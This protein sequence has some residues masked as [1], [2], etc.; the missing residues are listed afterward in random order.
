MS[1]HTPVDLDEAR[2]ALADNGIDGPDLPYNPRALH[3]M[4][5]ADA[6]LA[7]VATLRAA[8]ASPVAET[9]ARIA[10]AIDAACP[11]EPPYI[12]IGIVP[13]TPEQVDAIA[14]D[15][16]GEPGED[17]RATDRWLHQATGVIRRIV[18]VGVQCRID[19]PAEREMR[20]MREELARL[21]AAVTEARREHG[22]LTGDTDTQGGEPL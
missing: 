15:L 10:T 17:E 8:T 11:G 16:F 14:R 1:N 2:E 20:A 6:L 7:E 18:R 9:L 12:N 13:V 4:R 19:D 21:R 5:I 22:D 3:A